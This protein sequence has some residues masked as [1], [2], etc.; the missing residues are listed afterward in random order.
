MKTKTNTLLKKLVAAVILFCTSL[1]GWAQTETPPTFSYAGHSIG[2]YTPITGGTVLWSGNFDDN[3]MSVNTSPF[4]F[5]GTTYTSVSVS[6]NGFLVF[7]GT[8]AGALYT[9]L[10]TGTNSGVIAV[11]GRDLQSSTLGTPEVRFEE[12][13]NELVFQWQD[14]RRF[15]TNGERFS[16]QARLN[17]SDGSINFI[18]NVISVSTSVTGT[19]QVGLRGSSSSMSQIVNRASTPNNMN[20]WETSYAGTTNNATVYF[21]GSSAAYYPPSGFT[22]HWVNAVSGCMDATACNFNAD[23]EVDNGSCEYCSCSTTCGCMDATACN[24]DPN[25]T[26]EN[27]SCEYCSCS[28]TNCGCMDQTAC[29]YSAEAIV[30]NGTCDY[31]CQ[32]CT[33]P[34]ADN[35]NANATIDN[36]SCYYYGEGASCSTPIALTC[37]S[38]VYTNFTVGV[39]NDNATSGAQ[40]CGGISTGGQRWY[41]YE[42]PFSSTVVISTINSMT[43]FDTY[44]KVYTGS[45]GSLTCVG[46]NDDASGT[47]SSQISFNATAGTTYLIRV[48]GFVSLQGTFGLTI[49]CG[50]GCLDQTACNYQ[51]NAPFDDGSCIFGADCYGCTN[52]DA[53]NYNPI[54]VYDDGSCVYDLSVRVYHDYNGDGVHQTNEP[55]LANWG[56]QYTELGAVVYSNSTGLIHID[57]LSAA[58]Y[59]LE[60]LNS[61]TNWISSTP[62]IAYATLPTNAIIEFGLVPSTGEAFFVTEPYQGFWDVIH[63]EDGYEAGIFLNNVGSA[64]LNGQLTVTC[65]PFFTPEADAYG[66]VAPNVSSAGFAQWDITDYE[67]GQSGLFSF[68]IDGPGPVNLGQTYLFDINLVLYDA[69]GVEMYNES[70]ETSPFVAC[71]YDPNDKSATPAGYDTEHFILPGER[72][73]YRIRFQN[74]GNLPAEDILITDQI[75]TDVLD[76]SSFQPM[77]ASASMFTCLHDDGFLEFI[78]EDIYLPDSV[79]N[80]EASH[81]FVVFA[82]NTKNDLAPGTVI[83]NTANIYF[84][85]NP[86]IITNTYTHTIFDCNSFQG[87]PA[88][89]SYCENEET[90]LSATQDHVENYTWRVNGEFF[91]S[92]PQII[93]DNLNVGN[94]TLELEVSN[95]LCGATSV[96]AVTV[97]A[98]PGIDITESGSML[99]GP[100][101]ASWTWY[102]NGV[103]VATTQNYQLT[104]E[105]G[106]YYVVTTSAEGCTSTSEEITELST[107]EILTAEYSIYP[108][109]MNEVATLK[110]AAGIHQVVVFDATGKEV[111]NLGKRS[112]SVNLSKGELAAGMYNVQITG[113]QKVYTIQLIVN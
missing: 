75:D 25:A 104:G 6:V 43:N 29:N 51:A 67:P 17:T 46:Q 37:T 112:G 13:G 18:Y 85:A 1:T 76:L 34:I 55:G 45:C 61:T 97:N 60:I 77:Y 22:F 84:D 36:G 57:N 56:V 105:G 65:D 26:I 92:M 27:G 94:H 70:W 98:L 19:P 54:P 31:T 20:S 68:H 48:G 108:N 3:Y 88:T 69:N 28:E 72:L 32:G 47:F 33:D 50:G 41:V 113:E 9:P 7:G 74:T 23:A 71:S 66:T 96:S 83:A 90:S 38:N 102:H 12:V 64:N 103:E 89:V 42:A 62:A 91:S 5:N 111:L 8:P 30:D 21:S 73:E 107:N 100:A 16:F 78:F 44:L 14:V 52:T 4:N 24:F 10:S 35:Y 39:L 80:S 93:L 53:A 15:A 11:F 87:V 63:C 110:L 49:D 109:P 58:T 82:I 2:T 40:A 86:A 99:I 101:G 79:H 106:T 81:G 95:P 59:T